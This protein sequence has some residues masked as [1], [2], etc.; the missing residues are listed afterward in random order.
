MND[1]PALFV[2]HGAPTFALE[3]GVL[4]PQLTALGME[5]WGLRAAIVASAHW[6]TR[7]VQLMRGETPKTVHDFGGFPPALYRLQ[8]PAPGEPALAASAAELLQ[9]AGFDVSFDDHRGFDHGVWVPMRYLLPAARTPVFQMSLP[10][11]LD[12]RGAIRLGQALAPLRRQGVLVMGS[13]SLTHNLREIFDGSAASAGYAVEFTE[14][15]RRRV[16][17]RDLAGLMDYRRRAPH[18]QRAHPTE[19]HFLPL[20]IALGASDAADEVTVIEGG[21]TYGVLSMESYIFR[22]PAGSR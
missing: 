3:P 17:E 6:Q 4:G 8:Y 5:Q 7:G 12:A 14:W 15:V 11:D 18:A 21:M 10:V 9:A 19:E 22:R 20:L 13:G 1:A 16:Q 2:S